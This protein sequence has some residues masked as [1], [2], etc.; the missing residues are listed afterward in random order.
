MS[1]Q[2]ATT[3]PLRKAISFLKLATSYSQNWGCFVVL[4]CT[5]DTP[6]YLFLISFF[7]WKCYYLSYNILN[8]IRMFFKYFKFFFLNFEGDKR[9]IFCYSKKIA[10]HNHSATWHGHNIF[11]L[12]FLIKLLSNSYCIKNRARG[13]WIEYRDFRFTKLCL[14]FYLLL[15]I[16]Q[17]NRYFEVKEWEGTHKKDSIN[18]I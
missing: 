7:S 14:L 17:H 13:N 8:C 10:R 16:L 5:S 6:Y 9:S 4:N 15:F 11:P 12:F 1:N 2:H 3:P 18:K